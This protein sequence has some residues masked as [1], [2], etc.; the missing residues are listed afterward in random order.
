MCYF[1]RKIELAKW[2]KNNPSN[3]SSVAADA[4]TGCTRTRNNTLSVWK[5]NNMEELDKAVL[6]IASQFERL[7][8]M[9]VVVINISDIISKGLTLSDE[10]GITPYEDFSTRHFNI[11]DL[12]YSSLGDVAEIILSSIENEFN[13]RYRISELKNIIKVGIIKGYIQKSSLK[14]KVKEIIDIN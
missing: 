8:T 1:V 9:D 10:I 7:D 3:S 13:H 5:N 6:A 4:I 14:D 11:C 12:T 2:K